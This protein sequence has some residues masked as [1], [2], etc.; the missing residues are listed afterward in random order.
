MSHDI[1]KQTVCCKRHSGTV[2]GPVLLKSLRLLTWQ[3]NTSHIHFCMFSHQCHRRVVRIRCR[4]SFHPLPRAEFDHSPAEERKKTHLVLD[5]LQ[6]PPRHNLKGSQTRHCPEPLCPAAHS[7]HL[8]QRNN[9][10]C[11]AKQLRFRDKAT[12]SPLPGTD[13]LIWSTLTSQS[14]AHLSL[15]ANP[16]AYKKRLLPVP[17]PLS[18]LSRLLLLQ[19]TWQKRRENLDNQVQ[20]PKGSPTRSTTWHPQNEEMQTCMNSSD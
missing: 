13:P 8:Q 17:S 1:S 11:W 5:L 10:S 7:S 15:P 16:Q 9:N 6:D 19:D 18:G 2:D 12:L 20:P 4:K 3:L 14:R